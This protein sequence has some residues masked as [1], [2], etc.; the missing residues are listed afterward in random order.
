MKDWIFR[1]LAY[2]S[3]FTPL[4]D[5]EW[6]CNAHWWAFKRFDRLGVSKWEEPE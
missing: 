4:G 5:C 2:L 6:F 3:L 1:K